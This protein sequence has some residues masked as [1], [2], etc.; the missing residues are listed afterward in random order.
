[1]KICAACGVKFDSVSW[2][3]PSCS[4]A[5]ELIEGHLA[6]SPELA[7]T[8]DGFDPSYF[9][10]L[11]AL[12]E[13]NFWFR[14]CNRLII[15]ALQKY[16]S[17]AKTF[18][19]IGC[20]TGFV[21]SGIEQEV[22]HLS[23]FGSEIYSSGLCFAAKRLKSADLFQVDARRI[24]F[25]DE[26]D[27][28]GAFDVLEHIA[29]DELVLAQMYQVVRQNGGILITVPQHAFLWSQ[30]DEAACH[31]RRYSVSDLRTKVEQAGFEVLKTTSFVSLL[32]PLMMISRLGKRKPGKECDAL[33]E[34][35]I[36]GFA[37]TAMEK[38]LDLERS[39][40][41]AGIRLPFGGSLLLV[42]R[43]V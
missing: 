16:F 5:P 9:P 27:V 42:A 7:Q 43:K 13:R 25:E 11:M 20:G 22:S 17:D 33:A 21:L 34:L 32:L 35:R 4:S 38:V 37:N 2:E 12:E 26:F 3:C 30:T 40:I 19:E 29:E 36:S 18:F 1:M 15:W 6:F 31:V 39:L 41:K 28:V 14:S 10:Q 8:S 24:P 23:L